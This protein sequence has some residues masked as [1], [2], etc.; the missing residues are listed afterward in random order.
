MRRCVAA[1]SMQ[2]KTP[3]VTELRNSEWGEREDMRMAW[4]HQKNGKIRK[5]PRRVLGAAIKAY[6]V[7]RFALE[8]RKDFLGLLGRKVGHE[9]K[10]L[11]WG[12]VWVSDIASAKPPASRPA[13]AEPQMMSKISKKGVLFGCPRVLSDP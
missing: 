12:V 10:I 5:P 4:Q 2:I 9:K 11:S 3:N 13:S 8:R 1:Q 6:L 7:V